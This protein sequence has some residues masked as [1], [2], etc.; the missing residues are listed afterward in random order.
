MA[1]IY[2]E[3]GEKTKIDN[4]RPITLLNKDYKILTKIM[5]NRLGT[6]APDIVH[7]AQ[8][9]F[10]PGRHLRNHTQLARLM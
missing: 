5:A 4:Y 3:K 7:P 10:V 6:V 2:K 8:A 9:G 1:P